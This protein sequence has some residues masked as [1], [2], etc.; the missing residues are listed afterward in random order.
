[1]KKNH[2]V[3]QLGAAVDYLVTASPEMLQAFEMA[4]LNESANLKVQLVHTIE[5]LVDV[6]AEANL[7]R[8][9]IEHRKKIS[10]SLNRSSTVTSADLLAELLIQD[11]RLGSGKEKT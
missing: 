6:T 11:K 1:M 3:P 9:F 7:A 2:D 10:Q 4:R 8:T 5:R